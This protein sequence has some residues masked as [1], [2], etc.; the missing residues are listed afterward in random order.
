[1]SVKEFRN[2]VEAKDL[3]A[4]LG[5]MSDDVVLHSPVLFNPIPSKA[6]VRLVLTA[7][8]D[9]L[10]DFRYTDELEGEGCSALLFEA[11]V[12]DRALEGM[13]LL[14]FDAAGKIVDFTVMMR[15]MSALRAFSEAMGAHPAMA[16]VLATRGLQPT[17]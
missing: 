7:V 3:E 4:V 13:D 15:P 9:I 12:G 14:R 6:A 2:A 8:L 5:C 17:S 16:P 1:M 10:E 11:N